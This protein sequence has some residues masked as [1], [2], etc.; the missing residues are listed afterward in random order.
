MYKI[1]LVFSV[2]AFKVDRSK[3][4]NR[5]TEY[6]KSR[7]WEKNEGK[8]AKPLA[9]STSQVLLQKRE[10]ISRGTQVH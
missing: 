3:N 2:T 9:K 10:F 8:Y 6:I 5:S 7:I 1:L 4:Q